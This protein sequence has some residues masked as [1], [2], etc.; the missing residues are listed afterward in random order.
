MNSPPPRPTNHHGAP[1][2]SR[3]RTAHDPQTL[4]PSSSRVARHDKALVP[5][6]MQ[7]IDRHGRFNNSNNNMTL[8][9]CSECVVVDCTTWNNPSTQIAS[10][11]AKLDRT[12]TAR[13]DPES[14]L[15]DTGFFLFAR[16]IWI[17]SSVGPHSL[18][19]ERTWTFLVH[20]THTKVGLLITR[21]QAN[22]VLRD[23]GSR[24]RT[25]RQPLHQK[26]LS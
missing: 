16:T 7:R 9:L 2:T 26:M 18:T 22:C 5:A 1:S 13:N 19:L 14:L 12:D 21:Y 11:S 23:A 15:N 25:P 20:L 8:S 3:R 17:K 24:R 6:S 10:T 4:L